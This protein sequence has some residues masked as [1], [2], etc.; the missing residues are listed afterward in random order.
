MYQIPCILWYMLVI[1]W[2][3]NPTVSDT[4][5][6]HCS[7]RVCPLI[8][9]SLAG[10]SWQQ[11]LFV[12]ILCSLSFLLSAQLCHHMTFKK[13]V[14]WGAEWLW[15]FC[16]I[17]SFSVC[18]RLL[19]AMAAMPS[20]VLSCVDHMRC[21]HYL[22][23]F[24]TSFS[25]KLLLCDISCQHI[26]VEFVRHVITDF[27]VFTCNQSARSYGW[28]SACAWVHPSKEARYTF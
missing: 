20:H 22:M 24:M 28:A 6:L 13:Q 26:V 14:L 7:C 21:C 17:P 8:N 9:S 27:K 4:S 1:L 3:T 2:I 15:L 19:L 25:A 5:L 10:S 16:S 18:V 12:L 11:N 23:S